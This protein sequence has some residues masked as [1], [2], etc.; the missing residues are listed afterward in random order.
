[1]LFRKQLSEIWE[2]YWIVCWGNM[3]RQTFTVSELY[4]GSQRPIN[5]LNDQLLPRI[6]KPFQMYGMFIF[7]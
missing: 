7:F 5:L 1:M 4:G 2:L 6:L 3:I